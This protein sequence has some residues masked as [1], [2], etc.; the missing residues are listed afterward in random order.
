M[1]KR[2]VCFGDSNTWGFNVENM[3]RFDDSVRWTGVLAQQLGSDYTVIEEGLSGRTTVFDDPLGEGLSGI[4]YL[5]PCLLSH[6]PLDLLI[7]MLGTNDCKQR[8]SATAQNI[9]RGMERL[10]RKALQTDAWQHL[11]KVLIIAPAAIDKACESH[12]LFRDEMG[13]CSEK[14]FQLAAEYQLIAQQLGCEFLDAGMVVKMNTVDY[15]H[16]D[17]ENHYKLALAIA[18]KVLQLC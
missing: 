12:G 13:I 17:Q 14:S 9:A 10:V 2:I 18:E 5:V 11:P 15:M 3:N 4:D 6:S 8:F 7:I 16:L 1:K